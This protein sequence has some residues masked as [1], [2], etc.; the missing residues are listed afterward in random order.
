MRDDVYVLDHDYER[1]NQIALVRGRL[2]EFEDYYQYMNE[3]I[4]A[5]YQEASSL[6]DLEYVRKEE[7]DAKT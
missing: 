3:E 7:K 5:L 1:L 2:T 6:G 4:V